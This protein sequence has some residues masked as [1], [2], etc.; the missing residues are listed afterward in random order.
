MSTFDIDPSTITKE[1][2]PAVLGAIVNELK[3]L[4]QKIENSFNEMTKSTACLENR[5]STI[6]ET[7]RL[8]ER[9]FWGPIKLSRCEILPF[10]WRNKAVLL[11]LLGVASS[12]LAVVDY[13]VRAVQWAVTPPIVFP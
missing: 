4:N 3:T 1:S 13:A 7:L 9:Y 2:M 11:V 5:V 12:W 6:E 8:H 10:I